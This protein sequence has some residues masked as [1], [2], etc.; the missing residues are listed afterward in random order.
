M[1]SGIGFLFL[2]IDT[3][4][5]NFVISLYKFVRSKTKEKFLLD[6]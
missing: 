6:K 2:Y 4:V 5:D 3:L 1:P